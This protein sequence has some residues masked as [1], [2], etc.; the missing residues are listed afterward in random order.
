MHGPISSQT[1][2]EALERHREAAD[3]IADAERQREKHAKERR[4]YREN[5]PRRHEH[6]ADKVPE[7]MGKEKVRPIVEA[8]RADDERARIALQRQKVGETAEAFLTDAL[9][10]AYFEGEEGVRY[11]EVYERWTAR[12]GSG[13]DLRRAVLSGPFRFELGDAAGDLYVYPTDLTPPPDKDEPAAVVPIPNGAPV[14]IPET[15][16]ARPRKP[17]K[18]ADGV[19]VHPPGCACEWCDD[20]ELAPAPRYARPYSGGIGGTA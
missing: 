5:Y 11:Q 1:A 3:E 6:P 8:R 10:L 9:D 19:Y 13:E 18:R 15:E 2:V 14:A 7:L 20:S 16:D 12:G 17:Y 4:K